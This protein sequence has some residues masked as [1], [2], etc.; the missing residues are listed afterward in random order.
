MRDPNGG[1]TG[2]RLDCVLSN[3]VTQSDAQT[4]ATKKPEST[5]F[6]GPEGAMPGRDSACPT[7]GAAVF[8]CL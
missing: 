3:R 5:N 2:M 7:E 1:H 4:L 8:A 6:L